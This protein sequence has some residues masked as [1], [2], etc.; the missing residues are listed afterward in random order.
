M[1]EGIVITFGQDMINEQGGLGIFLDAFLESVA[2]ID[3]DRYW[4]HKCSNL[5]LRDVL[6]VYIIIDNLLYG[7]VPFAGFKR[8]DPDKPEAG[9]SA[10]G[11]AKLIDWPYLILAG[12]LEL[13]PFERE[14]KGF[15]GFRYSTTLW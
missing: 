10:N 8:P 2:G 9:Y 11:E 3:D 7:R 4:M 14:L 5:P 6:H 15:Q 1:P 13:C 12:P